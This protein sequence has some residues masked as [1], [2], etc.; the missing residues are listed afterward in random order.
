MPVRLLRRNEQFEKTRCVEGAGVVIAM[1]QSV[2]G[3]C[4]SMPQKLP[5]VEHETPLGL[6]VGVFTGM[7][8]K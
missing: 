1:K 3:F 2:N 8:G 6:S 7:Q 4:P 5:S